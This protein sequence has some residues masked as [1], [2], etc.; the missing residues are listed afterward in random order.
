M[1]PIAGPCT[2]RPMASEIAEITAF[3]GGTP[4]F[5][6]LPVGEVSALARVVTVS[7]ARAGD[8]VLESGTMNDRLYVVRSGSVELRLAS[9]C[10]ST[11]LSS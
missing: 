5:D 7:Y 11:S 6:T 3:L 9:T 8:V 1:T 4:P 10:R 2:L